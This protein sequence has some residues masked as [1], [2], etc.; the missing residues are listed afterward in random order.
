M[1]NNTRDMIKHF[2]KVSL[3]PCYTVSLPNNLEA[4]GEYACMTEVDLSMVLLLL[5]MPSMPRKVP[6]YL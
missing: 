4:M 6:R 5:Y 2:M 3:S 1:L